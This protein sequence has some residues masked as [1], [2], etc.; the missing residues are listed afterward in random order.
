[1]DRLVETW[2]T[3]RFEIPIK[4]SV[5]VAIVSSADGQY[6][7][8]GLKSE[9][10]SIVH[11]LLCH[12]DRDLG[13]NISPFILAN[14]LLNHLTAASYIELTLNGEDGVTIY[15]EIENAT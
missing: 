8:S 11:D 6:N 2:V 4:C 15:R 5:K 3:T 12:I 7:I 1:M 13:N 9:I 14:T 10:K